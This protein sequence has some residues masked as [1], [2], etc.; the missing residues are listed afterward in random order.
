MKT[1]YD[2]CLNT[3]QCDF[4]KL[5]DLPIRHDFQRSCSSAKGKPA[6]VVLECVIYLII[7]KFI[8]ALLVDKRLA[9]LDMWLV[10]MICNLI[11]CGFH[12]GQSQMI[13]L[14]IPLVVCVLKIS[15][16]ILF[17]NAPKCYLLFPQ[18]HQLFPKIHQL[19]PLLF[20]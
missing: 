1:T 16:V 15:P 9:L 11:L 20:L 5:Q 8:S 14:Y 2:V 7:L 17:H 4:S 13:L 12:W 3:A 6:P 18:M 10:G 19:F